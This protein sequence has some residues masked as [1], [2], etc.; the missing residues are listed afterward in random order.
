MWM[1]PMDRSTETTAETAMIQ[2]QGEATAPP[3][4]HRR[5]DAE[6]RAA[7]IAMLAKLEKM[8]QLG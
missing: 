7:M 5:L 4:P 2:D 3:P 1:E 6:T 8:E